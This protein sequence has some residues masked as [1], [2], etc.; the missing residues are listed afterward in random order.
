MRLEGV[1]LYD[2]DSLQSIAEQSL[3]LRRQQVVAGEQIIAAHVEDFGRWLD[4]ESGDSRFEGSIVQSA[5][6][7]APLRPSQS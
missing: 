4:R 2:I 1:F 7:E 6:P 5:I 3:A